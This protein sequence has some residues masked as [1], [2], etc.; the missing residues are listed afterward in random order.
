MLTVSVHTCGGIRLN[1]SFRFRLETNKHIYMY[2]Y[3]MCT[4][5][6]YMYM[7]TLIH[8]PHCMS[9]ISTG[10]SQRGNSPVQV[11]SQ[12]LP[13]GCGRGANSGHHTATLLPAGIMTGILSMY[14][15]CVHTFIYMLYM[16]D[17]ICIM[18]PAL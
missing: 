18:F 9:G 3:S 10:C 13:R 11:S 6:T 16:T 2:I 15:L 12:V 14:A 5:Y 1:S 17:L 8:V 7:D 4:L